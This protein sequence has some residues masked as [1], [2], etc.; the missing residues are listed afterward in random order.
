[1]TRTWMMGLATTL[2]FGL[3]GCEGAFDDGEVDG[4]GDEVQLEG[5]LTIQQAWSTGVF[6]GDLGIR[7]S[8]SGSA[9]LDLYVE[10][11]GGERIYYGNRTARSGGK[12]T[13]NACQAS[14]CRRQTSEEVS[15]LGAAP[16]GAYRIWVERYDSRPVEDLVIEVSRGG[17]IEQSFSPELAGNAGAVSQTVDL[18]VRPLPLES[19]YGGELG[20]QLSWE[21]GADLDIMVRNPNGET[22]YYGRRNDSFGGRMTKN[23]CFLNRCSH[24][25]SEEVRWDSNAPMGQ[26]EVTVA[27]YN[28][29]TASNVKIR[30]HKH[31]QVIEE[32]DLAVPARRSASADPVAIDYQSVPLTP[33]GV[34]LDIEDESWLTGTSHSFSGR[35]ND[36]AIVHAELVING[37]PVREASGDSYD[38][39]ADF[40]QLGQQS[41]ELLGYSADGML[42]AV[43]RKTLVVTDSTGGL[44]RRGTGARDVSR[45]LLAKRILERPRIELNTILPSGRNE[46]LPAD[47]F[48]NMRDAVMGTSRTSCY[49]NAN[50]T[51]VFLDETLLQSM[52]MIEQKHGYGYSVTTIAGGSHSSSSRHYSGIAF[53]LNYINGTKIGFSSRTLN[54]QFMDLCRSYGAT[55]VLGP[56]HSGHSTHIHCAWPR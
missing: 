24:S 40:A 43:D 11:P 25:A 16:T 10:T 46:R 31:R 21:G 29:A 55:E 22:I 26:Y 42:M 44:P 12:F 33:N 3:T 2:V 27:N 38:F 23:E 17:A 1:M 41:V 30:V 39:T 56:G 20:I 34:S 4:R 5:E 50:C 14:Q 18:D 7:A 6:S 9:D 53:D 45:R 15:F 47:S 54:R 49:G 28:G 19:V 13:K 48:S 52:L 35:A 51:D 37:R 36:A 8:W 32:H